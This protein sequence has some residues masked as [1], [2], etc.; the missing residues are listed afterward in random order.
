MDG[1][2]R[3]KAEIRAQGLARRKGRGA[4]EI[5][6]RSAQ[7]GA[8]VRAAPAWQTA[9]SIAAFVGVKGECDTRALLAEALAAGKHLWLP[10]M[11]GRPPQQ[12]IEF[13]RV[14]D[15]AQLAP[16][17]FGL[18]EPRAGEGVV[19]ADIEVDLVLVPGV[20]FTREG[21]RLGYGKGHYDVALAPLRDRPRPL[22]VGVCFADE[23]VDA[24]PVEPHDVGVHAVVTE[25]GLIT[26]L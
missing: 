17:P 22:R 25:E 15:L 21:L 10:R 5:A 20:A 19:L 26:C 18:L 16:A 9:G 7:L 2:T 24:L 13:V 6:A 1:Q 11:A 12:T 14:T 23:L 3:S 4:A 8:H